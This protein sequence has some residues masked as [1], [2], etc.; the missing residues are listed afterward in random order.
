MEVPRL[1]YKVL[2]ALPAQRVRYR[3]RRTPQASSS[4]DEN[5]GVSGLSLVHD[6][7]G[8]V[9]ALLLDIERLR[10]DAGA[11]ER[12][13]R[14]AQQQILDLSPGQLRLGHELRAAMSEFSAKC[15]ERSIKLS[16]QV[17]S[18]TEI[19]GSPA[20]LQIVITNLIR[21][22]IDAVS[23]Q[24]DPTIELQLYKSSSNAVITVTD[25]GRGIERSQLS[26]IFDSG[27][28]DKR[29]SGHMG[30]GLGLVRHIVERDFNG[31]V[32]V[33]S[34]SGKTTFSVRIPTNHL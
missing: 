28:S 24:P 26:R 19:M 34:V 23:G 3:I 16:L 17:R 29:H 30:V 14:S 9:T 15:E 33:K 1:F 4:I 2:V 25:N 8:S 32:S 5:F 20:K 22:A 13:L 31:S 7:S 27:Y 11:I 21:N 12:A 6:L 10:L 18:D